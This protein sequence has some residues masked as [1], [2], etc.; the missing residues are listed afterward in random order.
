[1]TKYFTA[2]NIDAI[3]NITPICVSAYNK[4]DLVYFCCS[5]MNSEKINEIVEIL[6][7]NNISE[8]TEQQYYNSI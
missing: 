4:N 7:P 5:N 3:L 8:I 6:Q 2:N 1:M